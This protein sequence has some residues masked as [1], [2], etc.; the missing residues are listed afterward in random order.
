MAAAAAA[1]RQSGRRRRRE[2]L[3]G[4]YFGG[5]AGSSTTARPGGSN[6]GNGGA[7]SYSFSTTTGGG[8]SAAAAGPDRP[9]TGAVAGG[10]AGIGVP[11][12][13]LV[14]EDPALALGPDAALHAANALLRFYR[15]DAAGRR[16]DVA[17]NDGTTTTTSTFLKQVWLSDFFYAVTK[18]GDGG[19]GCDQ[20]VF[21]PALA[22]DRWV[23]RYLV[24]A[25]CDDYLSPKVLLA[26]STSGAA[27]GY[28]ALYSAPADNAPTSW[29]CANGARAWPDYAKLGYNR[30]G[31]FVTWTAVCREGVAD[32]GQVQA[33]A[34]LYAF[35]K[36]AVY[37]VRARERARRE[38]GES[39]GRGAM[40]AAG[41]G[42][43][44]GESGGRQGG[45]ERQKPPSST[46]PSSS[47]P[48]HQP[49]ITTSPPK[50]R[51]TTPR[52]RASAS[53]CPPSRGR[54]CARPR[55]RRTPRCSRPAATAARRSRSCSRRRRRHR[56]TCARARRSSS[57]T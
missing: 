25:I 57:P 37:G 44:V 14:P 22:Y 21:A 34:M 53:T 30:D 42:S 54:T 9:I 56:A 24:A 40:A 11:E 41:G 23:G 16:V 1:A 28:W 13:R 32:A 38:A 55:G 2:L 52:C 36:W 39:E 31:V 47:P 27:T 12:T 15:V 5:G 29:R 45:N 10:F 7:Q 49:H 18:R 17:S 6:S 20:G 50:C 48:P 43:G 19:N 26:V 8:G 3:A 33:G 51:P 46:C 35:P 4:T